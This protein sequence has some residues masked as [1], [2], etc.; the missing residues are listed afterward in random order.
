M[1]QL[2][3]FLLGTFQVTQNEQ[4]IT[5]F[6]SANV[7]GLLVYLVLN[8]ER[9]LPREVLATQFWP[10]EPTNV[11][12]TN[13]R[14][15]LYQLRKICKEPDAQGQPFLIVN[16]QNVQFN[17]KS[18]YLLDVEQFLRALDSDDLETAVSLYQGELLPGFSTKSV[19]FE[20]WLLDKR[21]TYNRLALDAF[22]TY[23]E[24][25]MRRQEF[26]RAVTTARQQLALE[27]WRE[28]AHRQLML[29]LARN[30]ERSAALTQF[31]LCR[32]VLLEEL[33]TEPEA[34]TVSLYEQI[35]AGDEAF[36]APAP[37]W[38][39]APIPQIKTHNLPTQVTPFF[40]REALLSLLIERIPQKDHRLVTLVGPG[41]IGK[42]RLAQQVAW[43]LLD[44]FAH[45]IWF[46]PLASLAE[47]D[48]E[49]TAQDN[50]ATAIA[51]TLQLPL[52]GQKSPQEQ[53]FSFLRE[54]T[55]L[56]ILDNFEH[57][58]AGADF[59][60]DLLQE[61]A[62]LAVICTSRQP[63]HFL[64]EWV[65]PVEQLLTPDVQTAVSTEIPSYPAIQ[66]FVDRAERV[67]GRFQLTERN[68]QE[69][70]QICDHVAGLPLAIELA[71]ASLRQRSLPALKQAI[72][73]N[74]D[75]LTTRFRD[76][77]PRHRSVRAVFTNSWTLLDQTEQTFFAALSVFRGGF[78]AVTAQTVM[79]T[80]EQT[81][82]EFVEKSLLRQD[83]NGRFQMHELLRQF[84]AEKCSEL[85]LDEHI[86]QQHSNYFLTFVAE[87]EAALVGENP[88]LPATKIATDLDNVRL[89][90]ETAVSQQNFTQLLATSPALADF[91]QIRGLYHE[92][93]RL[94]A[95]AAANAPETS[96][97][98]FITYQASLLIRL[99][100]YK[101]ALPKI[102]QALPSAEKQEDNWLQSRLH[103]SW[104]ELL[105]RQGAFDEAEAHLKQ[106]LQIAQTNQ[107]SSLIGFANFHLGVVYDYRG[108]HEE[109]LA[110]FE[111]ALAIWQ[112]VNN[113]RQQGFTLISI[114]GV[115]RQLSDPQKAR[116]ALND[117][118]TINQE[119]GDLQGQSMALNNLS[120]LE[121][122]SKNFA[123]AESY[124]L[125]ALKLVSFTGDEHGQSLLLSN[126]AWNTLQAGNLK[127]SEEFAQKAL[128]LCNRI[129]DQRGE[130]KALLL[131]GEIAQKHGNVSDAETYYQSAL[132]LSRVIGDVQTEAELVEAMENLTK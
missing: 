41:G 30:G 65:V 127:E 117:G 29:A 61:V 107:Y 1:A 122:A 92:G 36:T 119:N 33:G 52:Q 63:L 83:E 5:Q 125:Q 73:D 120:L 6:R 86:T 15:A 121:I 46:V 14:Q 114:G 113:R 66:L 94:F 84:A 25:L 106:A 11:A 2:S 102:E 10:E 47:T 97:I 110:W 23:G 38:S 96:K 55:C 71:A 43:Q 76:I 131:L 123:A 37:V 115:A 28:E 44:R 58:L 9:P 19:L 81:L 53:L 8:A 98:Y 12:Q 68:A 112:L 64:A 13:F 80:K 39:S 87:Q 103:I 67:D 124:L 51:Q 57:V 50:I 17:P 45:G 116:S 3:I 129:G 32:D 22:Y 91:Y 82:H 4:I 130:G 16:R 100:Q 59:V 18:D 99:S 31:E 7:K 72:Q 48:D 70:I 60:M 42:S 109:S 111:R 27:P 108:H 56:L 74:I 62:D 21:Q 69:V 54:R 132:N 104:G 89:A 34:A 85:G 105:W 78:T 118:L 35:K 88:Q 26:T 24:Q 79:Q 77:P 101:L 90:W 126:L 95:Q 75:T 40:N 93:E 128:R 49:D 20:D